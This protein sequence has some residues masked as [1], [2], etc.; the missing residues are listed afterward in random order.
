MNSSPLP[1]GHPKAARRGRLCLG[2]RDLA[3]S[4]VHS[5]KGFGWKAVH[6]PKATTGTV[7]EMIPGYYLPDSCPLRFGR[8]V[9]K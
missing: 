8:S 1:A 7:V 6:V 3:I 2:L 5:A 9:T 4:T